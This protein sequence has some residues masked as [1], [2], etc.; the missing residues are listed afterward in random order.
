MPEAKTDAPTTVYLHIID[1]EALSPVLP[2][3]RVGTW[4]GE[5][6]EGEIEQHLK[7]TLADGCAEVPG[8]ASLAG[9][10]LLEG[11]LDPVPFEDGILLGGTQH[12]PIVA[13]HQPMYETVIEKL[14]AALGGYLRVIACNFA[15]GKPGRPL[16]SVAH[17]PVQVYGN[18]DWVAPGHIGTEYIVWEIALPALDDI[19]ALEAESEEA[20]HTEASA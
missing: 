1:E 5:L 18:M 16:A 19:A 6:P 13:F 17:T 4:E 8:K 14:A 20:M 9:Y 3:R 10:A 7:P 12:L 15:K 11:L 2:L